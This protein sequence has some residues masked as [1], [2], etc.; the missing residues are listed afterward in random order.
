MGN[1]LAISRHCR[2]FHLYRR[3]RHR[4]RRH[5]HRRRRRRRHRRRRFNIVK[6]THF[7]RLFAHFK[8]FPHTV[9]GKCFIFK[10]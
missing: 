9:Y 8:Q 4:R 6:F 5:R 10:D 1:S 3:R 7:L 2:R